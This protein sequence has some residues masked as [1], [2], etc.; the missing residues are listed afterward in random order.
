MPEVPA[1]VEGIVLKCCQKSPDRRNQNMREL[2]SDLKRAL[3][4]PDE[5]FVVNNGPDMDGSTRMISEREVARIK[6]QTG[7]RIAHESTTGRIRYAEN[8][9]PDF[10]EEDIVEDGDEY[11]Y[12]PKMEGVI[13]VLAVVA[14]VIICGIIIF[15]LLRVF[16][17]FGT[18]NGENPSGPII[19]TEES[20]EE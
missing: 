20:S 19:M 3:M 6:Q 11:D 13:T 15:L 17:V 4:N 7:T 16:D 18:G 12:D 10:E 14:G 8:E 2:I 9:E 5:D 1:S